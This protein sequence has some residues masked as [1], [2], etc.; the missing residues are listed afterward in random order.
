MIERRRTLT[1]DLSYFESTI[2]FVLTTFVY[3]ENVAN[4][5]MNGINVPNMF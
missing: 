3:I 1:F 2:E 5:L 4:I